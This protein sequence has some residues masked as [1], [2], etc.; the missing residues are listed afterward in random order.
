MHRLICRTNWSE[1]TRRFEHVLRDPDEFWN[2]NLL[3]VDE[4]SMVNE[5]LGEDL[6]SLG[7]PIIIIIADPEPLPLRAR[8]SSCGLSPT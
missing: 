8:A 5:Q 7:L 3:I 4:A 6:L 1:Q 2:I